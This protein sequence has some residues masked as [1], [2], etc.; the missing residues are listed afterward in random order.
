M[1]YSQLENTCKLKLFV[2]VKTLDT[3]N[4]ELAKKYEIAG[5]INFC[6]KDTFNSISTNKGNKDSVYTPNNVINFHTH[7]I[8]AYNDGKT[9]WGWP[10]G[11]DIRESIKFSLAGNK[12]HIVFT[13]EGIYTIQV[14]PCKLK[15]MKKL[16]TSEERGVLIFLIEEYFKT[17]HNFRGYSDVNN[18]AEAGI[19]INP[20]SYVHFINNFGLNNLVASV[21]NQKSQQ[22]KVS[23][24]GH[25]GIHHPSN[26]LKFTDTDGTSTFSSIPGSGFPDIKDNVIVNTNI[27]DY[28]NQIDLDDLTQISENGKDS[29]VKNNKDKSNIVNQIYSIAKKLK[30][31]CKDSWNTNKNA[32]FFVNFFPSNNYINKSFMSPQKKYITPSPKVPVN[33][34]HEIFIRVFSN[35]S[36]GCSV[37][38]IAQKNKFK[39]GKMGRSSHFGGHSNCMGS[40]RYNHQ[41]RLNSNDKL[42]TEYNYLLHC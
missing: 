22:I 19:N 11:E 31:D 35:K 39:I 34:H 18:L 30:I 16:L 32:W 10:S 1:S 2:P 13:V 37:H 7:P 17:T 33:A 23:N 8:S 26:T 3:I 12:A 14:S 29:P 24:A 15:K 40:H 9:V 21:T 6:D 41:T 27:K 5:V 25:T 38:H 28:I 4:K 20:Y 36:E 42:K